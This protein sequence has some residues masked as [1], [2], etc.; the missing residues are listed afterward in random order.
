MRPVLVFVAV[1]A[2]MA[3]APVQAEVT[4][5]GP[6]GFSV[7]ENFHTTASPEKLWSV[8]VV[9]SRWWDAEH[10]WSGDAA[11]LSLEAKAGGCWCETLAGGGS[12]RHMA[13]DFV[14]PNKTLR[15]RGALGPLGTLA[16]T[17]V[18]GFAIAAEGT[19]AT[20]TLSYQVGGFVPVD[21][22]PLAPQVDAVLSTQMTRLKA[23]AEAP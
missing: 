14:D 6:G 8:L 12:A 21:L 3:A 13:V 18:M 7:T 4:V 9:P 15:M 16:V 19:G 22:Q 23:A 17:G 5:S 11:N 20:I 1:M 2:V 10:T